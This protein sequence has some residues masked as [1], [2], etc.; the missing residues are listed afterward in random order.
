MRPFLHI[1]QPWAWRKQEAGR[2]M[3]PFV[4]LASDIC[5]LLTQDGAATKQTFSQRS[6]GQTS[7]IIPSRFGPQTKTSIIF[8]TKVKI[9]R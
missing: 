9:A 4:H 5:H 3:G 6:A 8:Y 2:V 1:S 7:P